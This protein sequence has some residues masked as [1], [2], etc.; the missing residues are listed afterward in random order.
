M[1]KMK[2]VTTAGVFANL[3]ADE[4]SQILMG[5]PRIQSLP[6]AA[7]N[8]FAWDF[9]PVATLF[10]RLRQSLGNFS[11]EAC[12]ID[13]LSSASDLLTAAVEKLRTECYRV[14]AIDRSVEVKMPGSSNVSVKFAVSQLAVGLQTYAS[15]S[16]SLRLFVDKYADELFDVCRFIN[17]N[18]VAKAERLFL[19]VAELLQKTVNEVAAVKFHSLGQAFVCAVRI[20]RIVKGS[21]WRPKRSAVISPA[22]TTA[23]MP[24]KQAKMPSEPSV[25]SPEDSFAI[26][27][28]VEA[29]PSAWPMSPIQTLHLDLSLNTSL[30]SFMSNLPPTMFTPKS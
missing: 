8:P 21:A 12:I 22:A 11:R 7:A 15:L 9:I 29:R 2:A 18:R 5:P 17:M 14:G 13:E 30:T 4:E 24:A 27:K 6:E 10:K 23:T 26:P 16:H 28:G 25:P 3:K 20:R 19:Q 1:S